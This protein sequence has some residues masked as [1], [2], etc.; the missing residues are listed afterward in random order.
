MFGVDKAFETVAL[1]EQYAFA[2]ATRS[3]ERVRIQRTGGMN[4]SKNLSG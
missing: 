1:M 2:A 4:E 3:R